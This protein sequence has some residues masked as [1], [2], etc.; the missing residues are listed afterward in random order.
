MSSAESGGYD[1]R[2]PIVWACGLLTKVA[3][4]YQIESGAERRGMMGM[5]CVVPERTARLGARA[6][7]K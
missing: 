3:P 1:G 2:D 6:S 5:N 4:H 7:S